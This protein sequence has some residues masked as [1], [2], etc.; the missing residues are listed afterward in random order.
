MKKLRLFSLILPFVF[1]LTACDKEDTDF[2]M[3][4]A[5]DWMI[6]KGMMYKDKKTGEVKPTIKAGLV[7]TG[8]A[9]SGDPKVDAALQ[10]G[11]V[12]K[13]VKESDELVD[14]AQEDMAKKPPD[15]SKALEKLDKAVSNR[16]NDWYYKNSRGT[17]Y[18]QMG[19]VTAAESDF[20]AGEDNC[21]GNSRCLLALYRDRTSQL[22]DLKDQQT[23]NNQNAADCSTY[24]HLLASKRKLR[25]MTTGS[26]QKAHTAEIR[27]LMSNQASCKKGK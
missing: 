12:I 16:P 4:F 14:K 18:L 7:A 13:G 27:Q 9:T 6:E 11:Y 3:D 1:V 20:K 25:G 10:A 21:Q 26:I 23:A 19:N 8:W 15:S 5:N 17:T 22:T 2:V 24:T